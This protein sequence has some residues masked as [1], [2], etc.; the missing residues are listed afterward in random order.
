VGVG[1]AFLTAGVAF[2]VSV[3]LIAI[4]KV[5][6]MPA[7][8]EGTDRSVLGGLRYVAANRVF[9]AV[10]GLSFFSS[11]FG[12]SYQ[13]LMPV[14][15]RDVLAVGSTGFGILGAVG[16]VGALLGTLAIVRIGDTRYRGQLMLGSAGLFGLL[17]A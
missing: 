15:A 6:P 8:R 16:G 7:V 14:F 13:Y 10:V 5:A 12:M 17:V 9:L 3:F 11:M 1:E 2:A 4:L